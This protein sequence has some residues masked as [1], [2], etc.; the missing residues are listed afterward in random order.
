MFFKRL[1]REINKKIVQIQNDF[2]RNERVFGYPFYINIESGN[3]C[4]LKCPLCPTPQ[5]EERI[6]KGFLSLEDAKKIID[7]FPL[8]KMINFSN[9]GEPFLNKEIF[10]IV[11]YAEDK[12]VRVLIETNLNALEAASLQKII[13]SKLSFLK[14]SIDGASQETYEKYRVGGDFQKVLETL[15]SLRRLQKEQNNY[16]TKIIWQMLVNKF[17]EHELEKAKEHADGLKAKF[18]ALE[19]L[20]PKSEA[21]KWQPTRENLSCA[22]RQKQCW[23]LWQAAAVNFN[24]DVFPCCSEFS[25]KDVLGNIFKEPFKN[26]W[27]NKR[28]RDLRRNNKRHKNC[29]FC[30]VDKDTKWYRLWL[31]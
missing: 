19:I 9:W 20:T 14:V 25:T 27:N 17:N 28:Y 26:I 31:N 24:G 2:L 18:I 30:H 21:S 16:K 3:I 13:D 4:N 29:Q 7:Q 10:D 15:K 6:P 1:L 5:R 11:R 22:E 23:Y 12:G 8:A